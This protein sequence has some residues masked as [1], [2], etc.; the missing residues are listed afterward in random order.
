MNFEK[1]EEKQVNK[2]CGRYESF[3]NSPF[4]FEKSGI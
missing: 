2:A 3:M 1:S 4:P